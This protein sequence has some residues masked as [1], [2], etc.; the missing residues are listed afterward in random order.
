MSIFICLVFERNVLVA[1]NAGHMGFIKICILLTPL[2]GNFVIFY[3]CRY[4]LNVF[5]I[6][7][8]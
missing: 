6:G 8:K 1:H 3:L 2:R 5:R 4:S 7:P